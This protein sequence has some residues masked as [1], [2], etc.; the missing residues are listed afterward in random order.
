[1]RACTPSKQTEGV[2]GRQ[3]GER[4]CVCVWGGGGGQGVFII[5]INTSLNVCVP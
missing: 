1:M 4:E 5:T 3:V 2:G